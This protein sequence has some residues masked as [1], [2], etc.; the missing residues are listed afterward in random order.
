MSFHTSVCTHPSN[1]LLGMANS[2]S[3]PFFVV[4]ALCS[5]ESPWDFLHTLGKE[6][7]LSLHVDFLVA[8]SSAHSQLSG[9]DSSPSW[10][11]RS[12]QGVEAVGGHLR[13]PWTSAPSLMSLQGCPCPDSQPERAQLQ[14]RRVEPSEGTV[15][16]LLQRLC[17]TCPRTN[18]VPTE[19][20]R[21]GT[22]E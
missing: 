19:P 13:A 21:P 20:S 1:A 22:V 16:A 10:S 14:D 15:K 18:S 8:L 7:P 12:R 9:S 3:G 6:Q 5:G 11:R 17:P 4:V 2:I